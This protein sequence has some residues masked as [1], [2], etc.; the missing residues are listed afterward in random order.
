MITSSPHIHSGASSSTMMLLV[1]WALLPAT[2]VAGWLYGWLALLQLTSCMAA[3]LATEWAL[4]RIMKRSIAPLFDGSAALTGLFL[5]LVL[6]AAAP[7]WL[8]LVGAVSAMALGKQLYGGLGF[9]PFNPALAARVI[10]LVS[11]PLQM[12]TWLIPQPLTGGLDLYDF[13]TD[14][15]ILF[16]RRPPG[17]F[18]PGGTP[19]PFSSWRQ[20]SRLT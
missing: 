10:L 14:G 1:I 5:A 17:R 12:T 16:A 6:P 18:R 19:Q 8:V 20:P 13:I 9:N 15:T 7:W 4:L 11:F 2:L 3:C